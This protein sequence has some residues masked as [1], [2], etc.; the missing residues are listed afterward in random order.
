MRS[1]DLS[2]RVEEGRE[3]DELGQL[4]RAFN[5]MTSQLAAQRAELMEA[6][7]QIDERRRFIESVLAGVSAGVIG[8]DPQ[9]R[10]D[11][12]NR[13]A[14]TLLERDLEAAIGRPLVD[15]VPEFG[16]LPAAAAAQPERPRTA[17]IPLPRPSGT[18][19]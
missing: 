15:V 7:R 18:R 3:D 11:L 10:I 4:A 16:P 19:P 5:R 2:V 9:G 17:E 14:S 12:P 8:L 6:Y 1:G 13:S